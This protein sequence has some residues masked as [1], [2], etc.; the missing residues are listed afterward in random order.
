MLCLVFACVS[1][2]RKISVNP[3]CSAQHGLKISCA[4]HIL[5]ELFSLER[6]PNLRMDEFDAMLSE[7]RTDYNQ[8]HFVRNET[9]KKAADSI[10]VWMGLWLGIVHHSAALL[11][12]REALW[13]LPAA[14]RGPF[15]PCV[16]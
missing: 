2:H 14:Q 7:F 5:Q 16:L 6:N 15:W 4:C 9:F 12:L 3:S 8:T 13:L 11:L 10:Q 1:I